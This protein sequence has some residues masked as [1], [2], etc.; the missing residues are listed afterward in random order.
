METENKEQVP[1]KLEQYPELRAYVNETILAV[2]DGLKDANESS[3]LMNYRA[4]CG[5]IQFD[6]PKG[7]IN[8]VIVNTSFIIDLGEKSDR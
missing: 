5:S 4:R 8:G 1:F 3:P 6:L 7:T 2:T